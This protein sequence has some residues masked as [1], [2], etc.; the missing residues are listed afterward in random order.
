MK[1]SEA[2][3]LLAEVW[4]KPDRGTQ[5]LCIALEGPY[6]P[7]WN[8][9]ELLRIPAAIRASMVARI[10]EDIGDRYVAFNATENMTPAEATECRI[11]A[12]LMFGWEA[13]DRDQA[14]LRRAA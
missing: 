14:A 11:L 1:E 4:A 6:V 9:G 8:V 10:H 12:C 7:Q 2:W 13:L 3:F 5:F